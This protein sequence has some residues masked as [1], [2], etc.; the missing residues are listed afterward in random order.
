VRITAAAEIHAFR[1]SSWQMQII[2][3][4]SP[5]QQDRFLKMQHITEDSAAG[6]VFLNN[7]YNNN[8]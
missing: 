5:F 3:L 1:N 8:N 2:S 6:F 7:N 4:D